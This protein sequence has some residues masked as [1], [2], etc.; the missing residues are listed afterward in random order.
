M[1]TCTDGNLVG[2]RGRYRH[3]CSSGSVHATEHRHRADRAARRPATHRRLAQ[4]MEMKGK[5]MAITVDV[6]ARP[7]LC[8]PTEAIE[9]VKERFSGLRDAHTERYNPALGVSRT[10]LNIAEAKL[11]R[12]VSSTLMFLLDEMVRSVPHDD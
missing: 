2:V 4:P 10:D 7:R 3:R 1:G 12:E 8:I 6:E 5:I 9:H 11:L